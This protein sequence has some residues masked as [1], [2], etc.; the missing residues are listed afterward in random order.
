MPALCITLSGKENTKLSKTHYSLQGVKR[1]EVYLY[2]QYS[3]CLVQQINALWEIL[4]QKYV[5]H[6][7]TV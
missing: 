1:P 5:Q 7:I 4:Q 2:Y 3:Y 6:A